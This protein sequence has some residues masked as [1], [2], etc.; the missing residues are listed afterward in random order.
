MKDLLCLQD[1]K[2]ACQIC[3]DI[4]RRDGRLSLEK[5]ITYG[6]LSSVSIS[7][8]SISLVFQCQGDDVEEN[9]RSI[10]VIKMAFITAEESEGCRIWYF[11]N[12]NQTF[13]CFATERG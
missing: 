11:H 4:S 9:V 12:G 10:L 6:V 3:I 5:L 2:L 13:L 8:M 1:S 7:Y